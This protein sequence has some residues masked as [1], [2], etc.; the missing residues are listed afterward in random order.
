MRRENGCFDR[1]R[2]AISSRP[3]VQKMDYQVDDDL[4]GL[5]AGMKKD[6]NDTLSLFVVGVTFCDDQMISKNKN[7]T[8]SLWDD[9]DK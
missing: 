4:L 3:H 9:L 7:D 6:G 2:S 1:K 8:S 5:L